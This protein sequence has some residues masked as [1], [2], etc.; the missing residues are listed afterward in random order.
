MSAPR[1][2][3]AR[4]TLAALL[5]VALGGAVAGALLLAAVERDGRRAVDD[6]LRTQ[7]AEVLRGGPGEGRFERG[8]PRGREQLLAGS[9]TFVQVAFGDQVVEQRG[10]VP[11]AA[12]PPP[13]HDGLSTIDI[14]GRSWRSLTITVGGPG[15][16][17]LQVLSS[18]EPVQARVASIRRLI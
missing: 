5:A 6:E 11:Y 7:A 4:L 12:P 2:L 17:R 15:D 14:G 13:A 3:R 8:G 16:P 10:D 18:L 9:G 1:S